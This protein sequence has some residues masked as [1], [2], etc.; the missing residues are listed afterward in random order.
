MLIDLKKFI[1][2]ERPYWTELETVLGRI[3]ENPSDEMTMEEV[4]RFH[5]LYERVS[6]D[7]AK[8]SSLSLERETHIYLESLVARA[9]GEIHETREK[10]YR[11]KPLVWF[12]VT[13]PSTFRRHIKAFYLATACTLAGLVAGSL[14]LSLDPSSKEILI[15]FEHLA[16]TPAERVKHEERVQGDRLKGVKTQGAAWYMTHNTRVS[17]VTMAMG[18]TYGVGTC[19]LLFVNGIMLG[20]VCTDYILGGQAKFLAG[21]LLP[22]GAVEI[23]ALLLAGQ[24]GLM[25]AGALIGWGRRKSLKLRLREVAEDLVTI[26][27]GFAILLVWAGIVESFLSQY[28]EPVLPYSFKIALGL[29]ELTLVILF[30]TRSGRQADAAGGQALPGA[31]PGPGSTGKPPER[32]RP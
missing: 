22:H 12:F 17:L 31:E 20:V 23:P 21:W 8:V 7:L 2:A 18:A 9:Y 32:G 15:P 6:A 5:Y 26:A 27:V 4:E 16:Q 29:V 3:D 11:F 1:D 14:F 13:L 24:A 19:L 10:P 28:H 25:L 30:F